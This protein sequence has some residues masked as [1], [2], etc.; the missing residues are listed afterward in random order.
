MNFQYGL[1]TRTCKDLW[2]LFQTSWKLDLIICAICWKWHFSIFDQVYVITL[3]IEM[4][5]AACKKI[6]PKA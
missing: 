5:Q 2:L 1:N 4:Y 3:K 6:S